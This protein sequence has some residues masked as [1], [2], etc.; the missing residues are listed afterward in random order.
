M[1]IWPVTL[2]SKTQIALEYAYRRCDDPTYSV[3]WVHA[4]NETAFGQ[5]YKIVARK[6]SLDSKLDGEELLAAE[7]RWLLILDNADDLALFGVDEKPNTSRKTTRLFDYIPRG[8]TGALLWTSRDERI[9]GTLVGPR[10]GIQV[11]QMTIDEATALLKTTRNEKT[12][13]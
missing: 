6:L 9:A 2:G 3:F 8:P 7:T 10:R 5:D 11:A 1:V 13:P 4:D 12:R